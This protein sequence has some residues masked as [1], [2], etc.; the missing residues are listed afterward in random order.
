MITGQI[1]AR[2]I[3]VPYVANVTRCP[4]TA[5][6]T[7]LEYQALPEG[8]SKE[9]VV[10]LRN[11][12]GKVMM[13]EL[14]PPNFALSGLLVN[15]LVIPMAQGRQALVSVKYVAGFRELTAA[16]VQDQHKAK[17]KAADGENEEGMPRGL[18]NRNKKIAE[19]L[20]K[21]KNEAATTSQA[22]DPKKKGAQ[23][24]PAQAAAPKKEEAKKE[25]VV[26][27]GKT[28][29]Q[30]IAEM[31]AEEEKKRQE[32][33]EAERQR[34]ADLEKD[35]DKEAELKRLGCKVYDFFP[36]DSKN[37]GVI[38]ISSEKV[39]ALRVADPSVLQVG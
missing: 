17:P 9:I 30:V 10:E 34:L 35:F 24:A 28:K 1:C 14:A 26:P 21:K 11:T 29:E 33:E 5:D 36:E 18:V 6:K 13:V 2:E 38:C 27:K 7:K 8:E 37:N 22:V 16:A 4:I 32:A 12:S 39:S 15:P 31:E 19:R 25:I 3:K 23:P 20:E